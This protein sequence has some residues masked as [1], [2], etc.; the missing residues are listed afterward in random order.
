MENI[1]PKIIELIR[2]RGITEE[3]DYLELLAEKPKKTYDPFLLL[4][5]E[6]GVDLILSTIKQQKKICIYG[7][8]DADGITATAILYTVLSDMTSNLEY[9][10]PSRFEEG[11]GL[12]CEALDTIKNR[13]ASLVITVDL[14]SSAHEE[15]EYAKGLGLDIVVTDHHSIKGKKADCILINPKQENCQYPFKE[16]AGCG[17]AYKLAQGIQRRSGISKKSLNDVL[18]LLAIGTIGDIVPLIDENRTFSK[19]GISKINAT[20]R[21]GL[22]KLIEG[23]SLKPRN[24]KSES[25][26]YVIVPHINAAGRIMEADLALE[27]LLKNTSTGIDD[28]VGKLVESNRE[29]RRLQEQT[30]LSLVEVIERD[31]KEKYFYLIYAEDAHEGIA[32]IVAGKLKEKYRRP[33]AIVTPSG[34]YLKGTSRSV[35]KINLYELLKSKESHFIKFGG[36]SMACGFSMKKESYVELQESLNRDVEI[37]LE[38]DEG[39]FDS[40]LNP[41]LFIDIKEI[42]KPF[43]GE[44]E[45][46][47]PFGNGWPKPLL[48]IK[49]VTLSKVA[50]MGNERQHARFYIHDHSRASLAAVLFNKAAENSALLESATPVTVF[51]YPE[52]SDYRGFTEIKFIVEKI[53]NEVI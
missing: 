44:L 5:M 21:P 28:M 6:A 42:T 25:L 26:A 4:N 37:M 48:A 51:G 53:E 50:Y 1:N 32:G 8:Y 10:I 11:Y 52:L 15:V 36:H 45:K 9:Y 41:D 31:Y 43:C 35:E 30:F 18:D 24:I 2:S 27:L 40:T 3:E 20:K 49:N 29:R 22:V 38:Q 47:A 23:V 17:V 13:G 34:E 46:L 14:G 19:Y 39:L 7:D 12:N 33:V 16:L